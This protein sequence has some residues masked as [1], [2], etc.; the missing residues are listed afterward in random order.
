MILAVDGGEEVHGVVCLVDN[1]DERDD[2]FQD[3]S[4]VTLGSITAE[5]N[6]G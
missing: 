2:P 5:R 6:E 1:V 4:G 3:G